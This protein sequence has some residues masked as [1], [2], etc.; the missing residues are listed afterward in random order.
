MISKS[1]LNSAL[2][3]KLTEWVPDELDEEAEVDGRIKKI[4]KKEMKA[5]FKIN[6]HK[7]KGGPTTMTQNKH[8][9]GSTPKNTIKKI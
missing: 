9:I 2:L 7:Q 6:Y 5:A 4:S 3:N 8:I 1:K